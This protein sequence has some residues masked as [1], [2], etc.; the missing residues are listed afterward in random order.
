MFF[1]EDKFSSKVGGSMLE[2]VWILDVKKFSLRLWGKVRLVW[3]Y[4]MV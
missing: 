3:S 4:R 2:V 1:L